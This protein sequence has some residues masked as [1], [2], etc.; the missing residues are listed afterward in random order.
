MVQLSK[1]FKKHKVE[2]ILDFSC[3]TGRN[4]VYLARKGFDLYAF[5]FTPQAVNYTKAVLK[6]EHLSANV[7]TWD[8]QR[9]NGSKSGLI[10]GR[11]LSTMLVSFAHASNKPTIP[12]MMIPTASGAYKA[13]PY[14]TFGYCSKHEGVK[15]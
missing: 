9:T 6:K 5:D 7:R 15:T 2:T 4:S 10:L 3:G 1:L 12:S 11:C 14:A 8:M 13:T